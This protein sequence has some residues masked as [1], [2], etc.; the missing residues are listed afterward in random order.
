MTHPT[1]DL[2]SLRHLVL[3]ITGAAVLSAAPTFAQPA[4]A[5]TASPVKPAAAPSAGLANEWLRGQSENFN[6]WDF[7]GQFR[8]RYEMFDDATPS[9][10]SRDFQK[11]GVRN[12]NDYLWLREKLHLGYDS[13]W[14]RAYAEGR[15]SDSIGDIDPK[16]PGRDTFDLQ[17]AYLGIGNL[18]EFPLE[19]KIGRQEFIYGDERLIG[20]SDWGNSGR[21]FDAAR[22]R[23]QDSSVTVDALT[24]RVVLTDDKKFNQPDNDDWLSGIYVSSKTW[25]PI[26]ETQLFVLSRNS[27]VGAAVSPR[28]IIS[29]GARVK[30]LPGKLQGWDYFAEVVEQVGTVNQANTRRDQEAAAIAVGG[31]YTWKETFGTPRLGLEYDF[32]T[33]DSNPNDGRSETFDNLFPTNH[34]HYGTMDLVGWRNI[35]DLR[36][37][38]SLKPTPKLTTSL[39]YH[40]FWLADTHD[41]FYPQAGAG[42][43]AD[44]YGRNSSF[45]SFV[46]SE[47]DIDATYALTGWAGLR[48]GYGHF[49]TGSYIDSSKMAVGGSTDADWCY[50]Q[51]TL[52]F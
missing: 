46:G 13:P 51:F 29:I 34:K 45:D 30:S 23:Y 9:F 27:S 19:L 21:S 41:F 10:P 6:P 5:A 12:E 48:A 2:H 40:L 37:G 49:F 7:G 14:I 17:Q 33:G 26:Q 16:R 25:V 52:S 44:G 22:L 15:N 28:D 31:G 18:K 35:H 11:T 43:N 38:L 1:R 32:S 47:L 36:S 50:L 39:D 20:A 4:P 42:R 8:A 3:G 24:G